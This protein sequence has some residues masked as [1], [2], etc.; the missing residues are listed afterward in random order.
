MTANITIKP[1]ALLF[2]R[3]YLPLPERRL[4][5][6]L[7]VFRWLSLLPALGLWLTPDP[8]TLVSPALLLFVAVG[9]SPLLT[10]FTYSL[11]SSLTELTVLMVFD[12]A[13]ALCLLLLGG[14]TASPF[15]W[16]ALNPLFL[17]AL[18]VQPR[19]VVLGARLSHKK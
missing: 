14:H 10:T 13:V 3:V 15:Y 2:K 8:I 17:L 1:Q 7:L 18:L 12:T 9:S 5:Y 19:G 16:Y 11:K 6:P 4:L